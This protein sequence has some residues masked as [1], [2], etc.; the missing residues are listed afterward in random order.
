[1][2]CDIH[3][4]IEGLLD[5]DFKEAEGEGRWKSL[6]EIP[7]VRNYEIFAVIGNV[8]NDEGIPFIG[9]CRF[10]DPFDLPWGQASA[11]Y[12]A[13]VAAFE[14]DGHSHSY[15]TLKEM[16]AFDTSQKVYSHRFVTSRDEEG[17]ITST[18]AATTGPHLGEV[19]ETNIFGPWGDGQWRK[20]IE[21]VERVK[22]AWGIEDD[23]HIRL[24]FFF[25]N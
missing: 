4:C 7:L 17:K 13:M 24:A 22:E 21:K 23:S 15:V 11:D 25:D 6:G 1:M 14:S 18:C 3:G 12:R 19:G 8:R 5:Y 10:P 9:E 20:L 2:G 16:K